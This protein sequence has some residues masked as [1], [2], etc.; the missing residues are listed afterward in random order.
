MIEEWNAGF[1]AL[2]MFSGFALPKELQ[3]EPWKSRG[4]RQLLILEPPHQSPKFC[5]QR[6]AVVTS[7]ENNSG[8]RR[9]FGLPILDP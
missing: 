9:I 6:V 7:P 3:K 4:S 8:R 1:Y 5:L 2:E